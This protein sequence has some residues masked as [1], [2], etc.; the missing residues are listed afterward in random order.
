MQDALPDLLR[1]L[2]KPEQRAVFLGDNALVEQKV[3]V[4]GATPVCLVDQ[5]DRHRL[6]LARLHQGENLEQLVQGAE[7]AGKRHQRLGALHEVQFAQG[8]VVEAQAQVGRHIRIGKLLVRQI[9]IEADR[10]GADVERA[11]VG[12]LHHA[13]TAAGHHRDA[14]VS[15]PAARLAHQPAERARHVVIMALGENAL[16]DGDAAR[17]FGIS[18]LARKRH[19]QRLEVATRHARL[20]DAGRAE[21]HDRVRDRVFF[22]QQFGLLILELQPYAAHDVAAEKRD[23]LLGE[24]VAGTVYDGGDPG[25][26]IRVL[27]RRFRRLRRQRLVAPMRMRRTRHFGALVV[28]VSDGPGCKTIRCRREYTATQVTIDQEDFVTYSP[29]ATVSRGARARPRTRRCGAQI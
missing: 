13:G 3:E 17:Q 11:A 12:G 20:A 26:R 29:P 1:G 14:L 21:H 7:P 19:T 23:V 10:L 28:H 9:D 24:A 18:R 6:H 22:E 5:H 27:D 25:R 8:E 2:G 15:G 4:H 16:G